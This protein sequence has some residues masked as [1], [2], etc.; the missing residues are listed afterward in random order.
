MG[1][2]VRDERTPAF[3]RV[4]T[5]P[6]LFLFAHKWFDATGRR[7]HVR[8]PSPP[9]AVMHWTYPLPIAVAGARNVY[10]LHDLVPLRLPQTTLDNKARYV[11]LMRLLA[12]R[13]D[14]LVTVSEA[15]RRDIVDLLD[16][17]PDRVTNTYQSVPGA[18]PL[19]A[20]AARALTAGALGLE[21]QGFHLFFGAIEPKKNVARL[22]EAYL[23][24]GV[25]R[26]LVLVGKRAWMSDAELQLM[27]GQEAGVGGPGRIVHLD[28]APAGL[29]R[30]LIRCART[31]IFPSLYEGFGLP[32][33]EAL[34]QGTPVITSTTASLPEVA[35]DAAVLVDPYDVRALADAI[36]ALDGDDARRAELAARAPAQAARFSPAAHAA[37][38]APVYR[39]LG[40]RV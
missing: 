24:S 3:A 20:E 11:R 27:A 33:L 32:V 2:V 17:A 9:P 5:A 34:A 19:D 4:W 21:P 25:A 7:L 23:V 26:P 31:V 13:A 8:L 6:R 22:L 28:Y 18:E 14:H 12:R 38:L 39:A 35:G 36:R 10:T 37:R 30:A 1:R 15:S 16:V 29:L 40:A